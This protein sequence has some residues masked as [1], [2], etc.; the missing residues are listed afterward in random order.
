VNSIPTG[1]KC[2]DKHLNGGIPPQTITLIYGE[3][4]TGKSTLALQCA[5]NCA[6]QNLKTFYI[7]CD[8]TF[9]TKRL[10][11]ITL[12]QERFEQTAELIL[13]TK[14]KDFTEQTILIDHLQDYVTKNFGLI[15][16]DTIN[17]LYRAKTAETNTKGTFKLNR[18]LN[19]QMA[20]LAQTTKTQHIPI[21]VTSQVKSIFNE[22]Q[23]STTAPV[24]TRVMQ[25]WADT[26]IELKP[27]ENAT[28][29][30]AK[31][32]KHQ[33]P[34]EATCQLRI[35]QTGIHDNT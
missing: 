30:E 13:L 1:S 26:I 17:S 21:I 11:Q 6:Q 22:T 10:S 32:E 9:S 19:R 23:T 35:T 27:T 18:E 24:A 4:E 20:L 12:T 14:P 28:V 31:L 34:Q 16:I 33:N 8:D 29:I 5:A 15:I 7:D 2:I 3:P 25:F